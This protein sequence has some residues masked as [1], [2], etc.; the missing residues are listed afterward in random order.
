MSLSPW[1]FPGTR[2]RAGGGLPS[3]YSGPRVGVWAYPSSR[4]TSRAR[5]CRSWSW[6]PWSCRSRRGA[7]RI[8][9]ITMPS[10]GRRADA[11]RG[12]RGERWG[13]RDEMRLGSQ[14]PETAVGKILRERTTTL[15]L[16]CVITPN[17]H[18][19]GHPAGPPL[20][21]L[22]VQGKRSEAGMP[23]SNSTRASAAR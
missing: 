7:D 16:R 13:R 23:P 17:R 1:L 18:D 22:S 2:T 15:M 21:W 8:P 20:R 19:P 11:Q 9:M 3:R 14:P 10:V 4:A 12:G 6:W 5:R